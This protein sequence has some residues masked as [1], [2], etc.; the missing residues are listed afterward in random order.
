MSEA[1]FT[2]GPW[3]LDRYENI[4]PPDAKD[5]FDCI[6][7]G[8]LAL[9][10]DRGELLYNR[11]LIACAPEMYAMLELILPQVAGSPLALKINKLLAKARGER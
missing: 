1:K 11:Y 8:G 2:K 9:T 6:R 3:K 4:V 5:A 7:T 10:F